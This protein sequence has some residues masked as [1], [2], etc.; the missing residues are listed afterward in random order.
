MLI[1]R[2]HLQRQQ[3]G[4][5]PPRLRPRA[6]MQGR[7]ALVKERHLAL[8]EIEAVPIRPAAQT[9]LVPEH[10]R[11]ADPA[12]H[13][14]TLDLVARDLLHGPEDDVL[15]RLLVRGGASELV[16]QHPR[17]LGF[18]G[19]GDQLGL[20]VA[21]RGDG[22]GD[23]EAVLAF[24]GGDERGRVGVVDGFG[25]HA[26]GDFVGAV[27]ARQGGDGVVP[28]GEEVLDDELAALAA[29][30]EGVST[31]RMGVWRSR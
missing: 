14:Q 17:H 29:G 30:L 25:V 8:L 19:G 26:G 18:S 20:L 5:R 27:G 11:H 16:G 23:D 10:A 6:G 24:E 3:V 15:A 1:L 13:T 21:R 9:V 31:M 12:A 4:H 28:V 22:H 2:Q 7:G